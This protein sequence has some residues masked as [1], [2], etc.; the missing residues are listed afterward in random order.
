[1]TTVLP[2]ARRE[3]RLRDRAISA[4]SIAILLLVWQLLGSTLLAGMHVIATPTEIVVQL[5]N[6]AQLLS[7]NALATS[8]TALRGWLLGTVI[9]LLVAFL[10]SQWPVADRALQR[11]GVT[12]YCL[13]LLAIAPILQVVLPGEW[14]YIVMSALAVVFIVFVMAGL[15]FRS[16][17]PSLLAILTSQGASRLDAFR[18]VRLRSAVPSIITGVRM[19]VPMAFLGALIAEFIGAERGLG[20][21][22]IQ[23]LA[24]S[25]A[26]RVWA[27]AVVCA[28]ISGLGY[29]LI[30]R[31]GRA[32]SPWQESVVVGMPLP[33]PVRQHTAIG[34]ALVRL[35]FASS[36]VVV[37]LAVWFGGIAVFRLSP[38]FAKTPL[39]I[40]DFLVDAEHGASRRTELF[41]AFGETFFD[42]TIGYFAG[43]VL[44]LGTALI[45]TAYPLAARIAMP[46]AMVI[47]SVP[48]IVILPLI[49][50]IVGRGLIGALVVTAFVSFFPTL[51]N[52]LSAMQRAPADVDA[53][54]QS[55]SAGR[56][57][58]MFLLRLPHAIPSILAAARIAAP[59]AVT[60]ALIAEWLATGRGLGYMVFAA[61]AQ[62][63]YSFV[64]A[65]A[66]LLTLLG[67]MIYGVVALLEQAALR[68]F[69]PSTTSRR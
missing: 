40:W 35:G 55:M 5:W 4:A 36:T 37:V 62:S 8:W 25:N 29:H 18:L 42:A 56:W 31:L 15:G 52:S 14:P 6:D 41:S 10:F 27:A 16:A 61:G 24:D 44:G 69:S 50:L 2:R 59:L 65:A 33:A 28:A 26:P 43:L 17:D 7:V 12:L 68:R 38:F 34:R 20:L 48:V 9:A 54:L 23:A 51:V 46:I 1:M 47:Q 39:D 49:V 66:A 63:Q 32:L 13:P 58:R 60:G 45:V 30:G 67:L 22:L 53:V 57:Q 11:A 3:R 64:W 21:L 19:A